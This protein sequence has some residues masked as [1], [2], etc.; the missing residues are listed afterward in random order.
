[1]RQYFIYE[2]QLKNGPFNFEQL[3]SKSLSKETPVWYEGMQDW[4]VAGKLNELKEYFIQ[5][6][7]PPPLP[8][9]LENNTRSRNEILNSF[10]HA[11]ENVH[12]PR[13]K[14]YVIPAIVFVFIVAIIIALFFMPIKIK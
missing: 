5:K 7:T 9:D 4:I 13:K 14:A 2:G 6:A 11:E 1:M 10:T 3:K 8:K 12:K